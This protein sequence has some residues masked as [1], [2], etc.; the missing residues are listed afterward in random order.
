MKAPF[1]LVHT[2]VCGPFNNA[3]LSGVHY[4]L[5]FINDYIKFGW[6]FFL[7]KK[8]IM[9]FFNSSSLKQNLNYSLGSLLKP[10]TLTGEEN[11]SPLIL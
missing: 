2:N 6:V 3:S 4:I 10:Y 8:K 5:I 11:I 9:F 7:K 1:D